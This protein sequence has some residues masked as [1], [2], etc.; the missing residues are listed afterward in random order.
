MIYCL[1]IEALISVSSA[2]S[3]SQDALASLFFAS[4]PSDSSLLFSVLSPISFSAET[5]SEAVCA[6]AATAAVE[7]EVIALCLS[8][9]WNISAMTALSAAST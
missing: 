8:T 9:S 4:A 7:P 3:V 6:T 1:S 2:S 5:V